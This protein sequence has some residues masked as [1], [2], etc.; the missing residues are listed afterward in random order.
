[1]F[2]LRHLFGPRCTEDRAELPPRKLTD[3]ILYQECSDKVRPYGRAK[4]DIIYDK[5]YRAWRSDPS[6]PLVEPPLGDQAKCDAY[7]ATCD[8]ICAIEPRDLHEYVP[9]R[10]HLLV[11]LTNPRA[12]FT[13]S[14]LP[15]GLGCKSS[16]AYSWSSCPTGMTLS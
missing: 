4:I 16:R 7:F 3:Y 15:V 1:M 5:V 14:P 2:E 6:N 13:R 8:S 11:E 12:A 10:V 9:S